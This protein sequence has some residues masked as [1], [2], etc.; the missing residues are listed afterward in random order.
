MRE[1][2]AGGA[3]RSR[4]EDDGAIWPLP[5]SAESSTTSRE[6][7]ALVDEKESVV[8]EVLVLDDLADA[9]DLSDRAAGARED[10]TEAEVSL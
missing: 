3:R 4:G 7:M 2:K 9:P 10:D 1:E 8:G 6:S 5:P